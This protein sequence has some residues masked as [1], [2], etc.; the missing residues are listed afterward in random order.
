MIGL[1]EWKVFEALYKLVEIYL[2]ESPKLSKFSLLVMFLMKLRLNLFDD[3]LAYRFGVHHSTVSRNFHRV[4]DVMAVRTE[5]LIKWPERHVLRETMPM[6]FR[7]FFRKCCVIIDCTEVST[8]G[9]P[10]CRHVLKY[11]V[12]ISTTPR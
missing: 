7:R 3:D 5:H 4:L 2:P 1:H 12:I 11:G 10:I 9:L 8:E 6:S